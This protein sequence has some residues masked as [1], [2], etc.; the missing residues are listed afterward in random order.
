MKTIKER[1]EEKFI[2]EPNTGCWLWEAAGHKMSYG[3]FRYG[4]S[5]IGAH[6][7]SYLIYVGSI[8]DGLI[9]CHKCDT[10]A[11]VNPRHLFVGTTKDNSQDMSRKGRGRKVLKKTHC[12]NGHLLEGNFFTYIALGNTIVCCKTCERE[13]HIRRKAAGEFK[14]KA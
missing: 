11:C 13:R 6:R 14:K 5:L 7:A 12:K 9:V 2:P 4:Q 10:P 1:F 3:S 8:Q